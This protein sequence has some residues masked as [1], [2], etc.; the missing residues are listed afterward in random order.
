MSRK[1]AAAL[2][3]FFLLFFAT[4]APAPGYEFKAVTGVTW[5]FDIPPGYHVID[6]PEGLAEGVKVRLASAPS[7]TWQKPIPPAGEA[8]IVVDFWA[9]Q[10]S[11]ET[12]TTVA[13][14]QRRGATRMMNDTLTL[15]PAGTV[16]ID[17]YAVV[18][19]LAS[20]DDTDASAALELI[21]SSLHRV[22]P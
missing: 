21:R 1:L 16:T 3:L 15:R 12:D 18:L 20:N 10:A 4:A 7:A 11:A 6:S 5:G 2:L 22:T 8:L 9:P 13:A 19:W 17:G 14:L